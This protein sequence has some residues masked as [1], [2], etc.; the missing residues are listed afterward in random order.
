M[1][2][3]DQ[4]LRAYALLSSLRENIPNE[5]DIEEKWVVDYHNVINKL[6]DLYGIDLY[7]FKVPVDRLKQII[8]WQNLTSGAKSY[9][10]GLWCDREILMYKLDAVLSYFSGLSSGQES[11]IGFRLS[12]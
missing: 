11:K 6:E 3:N 12:S 10:E 7:D 4:T 2:N 8:A 5:R 1:T 9:L